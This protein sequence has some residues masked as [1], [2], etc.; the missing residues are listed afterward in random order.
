MQC[1]KCGAETGLEMVSCPECGAPVPQNVEGFD[2]TM[3]FQSEL[4]EIVVEN[5]P[6]AVADIDKF[7]G[8]LGDH[9]PDH[10]KERRLLV[11]MYRSGV[12]KILLEESRKDNRELAIMKARSFL[13]GDMFLAENAAEFVISCFTYMLGWPYASPLKKTPAA[14]EDDSE[15]E[16]RVLRVDVNGKI[17]TPRNARK[18]LLTGNVTI[19]EGFTKL[20][21]FAF[22]KYSSLRTIKLPSTLIAIGEY[23]FSSCKRLRGLELPENLR[24]IKQGAFSQCQNLAVVKIPNGVLEIEDSTFSFC[25]SLEV[26]E[27]PDSVSSIGAEAFSGCD[28]LRKLFLPESVKFIDKNAF[29]YCPNITIYCIE[30]SYVHKYCIATGMNFVLVSSALEV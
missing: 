28:K 17:F 25:T 22:D 14:D 18:F 13:V 26:I 30:N 27:I 29:S 24:L 8:L 16:K 4:R 12:L 20:E 7:I 9:V 23:C 19:P 21:A 1:E 5:G 6:W 11:N 2:N 10:F 15:D 3:E